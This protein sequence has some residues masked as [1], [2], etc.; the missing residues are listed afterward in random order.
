MVMTEPSEQPGDPPPPP[1][2]SPPAPGSADI[3]PPESRLSEEQLDWIENNRRKTSEKW[4]TDLLFMGLYLIA[5]T[6][7]GGVVILLRSCL[8]R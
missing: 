5:C 8:H 7:L 1:V 4:R 3:P 2:E 6:L